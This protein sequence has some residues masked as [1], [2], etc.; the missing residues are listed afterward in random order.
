MRFDMICATSRLR[1]FPSSGV[2]GRLNRL[3]YRQWFVHRRSAMLVAAPLHRPQLAGTDQSRRSSQPSTSMNS[4]SLS[5]DFRRNA[6]STLNITS[7]N[8]LPIRSHAYQIFVCSP[9][10]VRGLLV[11]VRL[12]RAPPP[13][14]IFEP[15]LSAGICRFRR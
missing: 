1:S 3:K 2:K 12:F 6:A 13:S 4:L 5:T 15:W 8:H 7:A 14:V 9:Q 10:L 11:V